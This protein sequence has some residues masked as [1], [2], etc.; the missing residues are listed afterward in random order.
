MFRFY[1]KK[2]ENNAFLLSKDTLKHIKVSRVENK[3][4]ICVYKEIFYICKLE[5]NK[6]III[7]KLNKNNEFN[8][9]IIIAAGIINIKRFEWLI[10]KASE[11]GATSLIPIISDNTSVKLPKNID[12]KIKRWNIIASNAAEQSFRNKA[13]LVKKPMK[14]ID[15]INIDIEN[16]YIAHEK[17]EE[18]TPQTLPLNSIFFIG[19]EGGFSDY[20]VDIAKEK[21]CKI[22]SLGK[23]I[24]RAETASIFILSRVN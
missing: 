5:I 1:V 13:M 17:F 20:E 10:Q 14:F 9:Q 22:I 7:K 24:L 3:N 8:G 18:E 4:F 21:S 19:P 6:A 11:L 2:K 15:A 23:R 12:E 16:K